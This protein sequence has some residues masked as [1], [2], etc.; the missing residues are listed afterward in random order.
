MNYLLPALL[1]LA[2]SAQ[3]TPFFEQLTLPAGQVVTVSSGPGEAASIGSYDVRLYTGRQPRF[4]LDEFIAGVVLPRDGTIKAVK[5]AD[6]NGDKA[7][8]LIV[9]AQSAGSGGYLS[10]DA[11]TVSDE[12]IESFNHVDGLTPDEDV[13]K[14]LTAPPL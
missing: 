14:A 13:L 6:L 11:F 9:I 2:S 8:E 12:G 10:A 4:P 5:L 7:P 1:V 3:A